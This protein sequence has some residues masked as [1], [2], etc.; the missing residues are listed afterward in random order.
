VQA[1]AAGF[2]LVTLVVSLCVPEYPLREELCEQY[3]LLEAVEL[4]KRLGG[5]QRLTDDEILLLVI[6]AA[7]AIRAYYVEPENN[8][9]K[10]VF[11]K[12]LQ[13]LD[14]EEV[15][16]AEFTMLRDTPEDE[17]NT[18]RSVEKLVAQAAF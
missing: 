11:D 6:T 9:A 1:G 8:S 2:A 14:H 5:K 15:V 12:L 10:E 13:I 16:R 17:A 7:Q 4:L 3:F 18:P